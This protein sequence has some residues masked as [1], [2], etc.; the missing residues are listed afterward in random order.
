MAK[1]ALNALTLGLAGAWSPKVRA[2]VVLP[3]PFL[4]DI[5]DA[6][7]EGQADGIATRNPMGRIGVPDDAVGVCLFLASDASRYVNG[8]Q[9]LLDGGTARTL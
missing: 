5:A 9:I 2:N 1:A 4:T 7:P 8:A 6:W 3:G